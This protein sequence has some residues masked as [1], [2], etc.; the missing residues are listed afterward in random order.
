M[1]ILIIE[2]N[3]KLLELLLS[4][5]KMSGHEV[6]GFTKCTEAIEAFKVEAFDCAVIDFN[7]QDMNGEEVNAK[8]KEI[9]PELPVLF[10]TGEASREFKLGPKDSVL[11]KPFFIKQFEKA[12]NKLKEE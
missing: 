2:D 1:K 5:A 9:N 6:I 4:M 12:L 10:T 8:L 3:V 7:L 11:P